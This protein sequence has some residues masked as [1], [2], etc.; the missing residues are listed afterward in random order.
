[1]IEKLDLWDI[2]NEI[3]SLRD[4]IN[5]IGLAIICTLKDEKIK[6][7]DV[8]PSEELISK[9]KEFYKKYPF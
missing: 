9:C 1:M 8:S 5:A 7:D 3:K 2:E 6:L 4:D